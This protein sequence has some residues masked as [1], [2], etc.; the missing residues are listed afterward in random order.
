MALPMRAM[1][2]NLASPANP[3]FNPGSVAKVMNNQ[4]PD[5]MGL[6][7]VCRLTMEDLVKRLYGAGWASR[8]RGRGQ[9]YRY[10]AATIASVNCP[11]TG[12][13]AF[14]NAIVSRLPLSNLTTRVLPFWKERRPVTGR[15]P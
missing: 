11:V 4:D 14:G 2:W 8:G 3:H 12:V 13:S 5:V 6:Q 10:H 15:A 1:T 7:E 9:I